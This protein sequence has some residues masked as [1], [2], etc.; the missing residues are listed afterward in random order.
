M[1]NGCVYAP[2]K[3]AHTFYK[4][5]KEFGYDE[6]WRIYGIAM[7]PKFK[8]NYK[9]SLSLDAEGVPTFESLMSNDY[10]LRTSNSSIREFL[11]K[12]FPKREDTIDN[13]NLTLEEAK[14]FN[15]S[16]PYRNHLLATVGYNKGGDIGVVLIPRTTESEKKFAEQYATNLLNKRLSEIL[17][18]LGVNIGLLQEVEVNSGRVGVTDFSIAK[19]IAS[20]SISMI[21]VANNMEGVSALSEEFSHLI[22]GAMRDTPLVKRNISALSNEDTLKEILGDDYQDVYNFYDGDL[23]LMAEEALGHILQERLIKEV[24]KEDTN[25]Q[26]RLV[27]NIQSKFKRIREVDVAKAI[28]EADSS[29]SSLAGDILNG[30]LELNKKDII[31]SQREVQF[32][33]LSKRTE[34][35]ISILKNAISTESKRLKI[36]RGNEKSSEYTTFVLNQ[37]EKSLR[38]KDTTL[39][40]LQYTNEAIKSL[41]NIQASLRS[42][43]SANITEKFRILRS[44]RSTILSYSSFIDELNSATLDESNEEENDFLRDIVIEDKTGHKVVNVRDAL[45]E[46][47]DL[48]KSVGKSYQKIVIPTFAE[49]LKPVLGE[50][51]TIEMGK[52]AGSKIS[53]EELLKSSESDISL[54]DRWLDSMGNSSDILLRAFDKIYKNAVDS[55]R[56][57]SIKDFRKIQALMQEAESY[58]I[59]SYDWMFERYND[60]S[61]TGNYISK[62]NSA[63]YQKDLD[64]FNKYLDDKYGKN[65]KGKAL[66]GKL[67]ERGEWYHKHSNLTIE[68]ERVPKE[69]IYINKDYLNLSENQKTIRNRFLK[70]KQEMDNQYP[71]DRVSRLKAIQLR[72]DGV[73]RFIDSAKSPSSI[74]SNIKEHI[75]EEFIDRADD[76]ALFGGRSGILDFEGKEFMMLPVLFTTRLENPNELSTDI[77]G[78]LMAYTAA[79]NNYSTL[80]YIVDPLEVGRSIVSDYREV[81][82][83]RGG[84]GVVERFSILGRT[85]QKEA[86]RTN[87]SNI[88]D[89]LNDFFASQIYGQYYKDSGVF[90]ILG[91]KVNKN[92]LVSLLLRGSSLAQLGFN[93]LTNLANAVTGVAMQNIEAGSR[94]FFNIRELAKADTI[95]IKLIGGALAEVNSRVKSNKLSLFNELFNIRNDFDNI[96][97]NSMRKSILARIFS[98]DIAY[99][100]Q[101]GGDHWLYMRTAIAMALREKVIVPGRGEMSLW[102]ALEI[103]ELPNNRDIKE[104]EL[105][106]GTTDINGESF[107]IGKFSRK[108]AHVNQ[109]LFGIYNNDDRNAAQRVILG[110]LVTQYRN[111][112]KP[113]FNRRFQKKQYNLDTESYEEGYYV[114]SGRIVLGLIRGQYQLGAVWENLTNI[115]KANV[116]RTI[117]EMAQLAIVVILA[118]FINWPDDKNRPWALK[119]AEYSAKRLEHELGTLAPSPIML[120]ELTKTVKSP[121]ASITQ[122][123]NLLNLFTSLMDPRDWTNEIESGKYEGMST[124]ERNALKSGLPGFAQF[125]QLDRLIYDV[126]NAINYYARPY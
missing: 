101:S 37:L 53:I 120:Q 54:L 115:E 43:N 35:N 15:Q 124:L 22:I 36:I 58:G 85:F 109:T 118:E 98:T 114:T 49:F 40:V 27:R 56:L 24:L 62:V 77:F 45:K 104:M 14:T 23:E 64:E 126:D 76:D 51:I 25:L 3:G 89:R 34:R 8:E 61:L 78:S 71:P 94:E 112:M 92:K 26:D 50:E 33:A 28:N 11:G 48:Y 100:G 93:Y 107:D 55:S 6:A 74:W 9:N 38:D 39:G 7:N 2:K 81:K 13:Y 117:V 113:Q 122:V 19:R 32:N 17:K 79:S 5:K 72:K 82:S 88:L 119:L 66:Q 121:A 110:R 52:K 73:Q 46:L 108:I 125:Q 90:N 70:I 103:R 47:N 116:R 1:A 75:K 68:G 102:D 63:Q 12:N 67:A 91:T 106:E 10:I 60:G 31:Q 99:L 41:Y 97:H 105:P 87:G 42:L 83:T 21:R 4:L 84:L 57:K 96:T 44:I 30:N 59:R 86:I 65:P 18:P 80:D 123:Q 95:Y 20:D 111:W 69:S 29:M 16:S